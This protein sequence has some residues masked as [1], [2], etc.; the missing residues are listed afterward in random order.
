[1]PR[2]IAATILLPAAACGRE[3]GGRIDASAAAKSV[4]L[5]VENQNSQPMELR[6]M[7]DGLSTV[8]GAV[9]GR[10]STSILLDAMMFPAGLLY[11]EAVAPDGLGHAI[12]GPLKAAKGD[13][14]VFTVSSSLPMSSATVRR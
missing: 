12:A 10:D 13:K 14:I 6:M 11:V 9:S 1:M 5:H 7:L 8:V 4:V 3:A 2:A